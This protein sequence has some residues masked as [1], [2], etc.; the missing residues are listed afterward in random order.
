MKDIDFRRIRAHGG[1]RDRGFE[2]LVCQLASLEPREEEAVFYRKGIGADGGVECFA[3]HADGSETGWQAKYFFEFGAPQVGQLNKSIEQALDKHTKLQKFIVGLPFDLR[4][5]RIGEK[6]T[7]LERWERWKKRWEE[8]ATKNGRS[9][10]IALWSASDL[11]ERLGRDAPLYRG[12]AAF[13]FDEVVLTPEWFRSKF[14]IARAGL[15]ARYTP[16]TNIEL[17]IRRTIQYFCRC[18]ALFSEVDAWSLQVSER[19]Y[20]AVEQLR[21]HSAADTLKER[22]EKLADALQ[23]LVHQLNHTSADPGFAFPTSL[24]ET[25]IAAVHG[26]CSACN[27]ALWSLPTEEGKKRDD[28]Y[29]EYTLSQLSGLLY[30]MDEA[31]QSD[32]WRIV[33]SR[34]L[35]VSGDAGVG[36]SHLFGDAAE[37][38]I[39]QGW[40]ALL[41]LGGSFVDGD[42]W[43]QILAALGLQN[44]TSD[45]FLGALDAAGQASGTR[46]VI[47]IDAINERHGIDLWP[48]RLAAF[49]KAIEPYPH[50]GVALSCRTAYLPYI[51]PSDA[52]LA[53]LSRIEHAGFAGNPEAANAYLDRRGIVR[54]AAPNLIPEFYNPLFL[55]TCCDLLDK[56]GSKELP[57]GL[58]GVTSI[59]EFY[60]DAVAQIIETRL[61]LDRRRQIVSKALQKLASAFEDGYRGYADLDTV[62]FLLDELLPSDGTVE[63]SLLA[64]L[65]SE[66]V[67][68]VEPVTDDD[69]RLSEIVRFTFERYSDHRIATLLLNDH[70]VETDPA[71]SFEPGSKLAEFILGRDAYERAGVIEALAIQI[72][73]RCGQELPDLVPSDKN[74]HRWFVH[75]AFRASVLWRRQECFTR[76]TLDL[77]KETSELTGEDEVT[78]VLIAVAT[79]PANKFNALFLHERLAAMEMPERDAFWSMRI[80]DEGE[81]DSSPI[82]TLTSW[83]LQNGFVAIEQERARL[84]ATMLSWLFTTSHRAVRDRATKALSALLAP[85]LSIGTEL[86]ERFAS[87]N[88][89]YVLDRVL[90]AIYGAA[91]QGLDDKA[92]GDLAGTVNRHIFEGGEPPV[93]VLIRDHARGIIELADHRG[94]LSS[95]IDLRLVRPPYRSTWPLETVTADV[96][97]SYKQDYGCGRYS[98]SI[99]SSTVH[100]GDFARYVIDS[101]VDGWT[102]L[103]IEWAGSTRREI[104]EK[105]RT[106]FLKAHPRSSKRIEDVIGAANKLKAAEKREGPLHIIRIQLVSSRADARKA[107]KRDERPA[108][109]KELSKG[110]DAAERRLKRLMSRSEREDYLLLGQPHIHADLS[111]RSGHRWPPR[112]DR[113]AMRRWVCKRAHDLGWT[114]ERFGDQE[115]NLRSSG[116]MEHRVERIGKKYQWIAL[117][118]LYAHL[119]DHLSYKDT[120]DDNLGVYDGPWG[121]RGRDIDPSLLMER[122]GDDGWRSWDPTWWMPAKVQLRHVPPKTRLAWLDSDDDFVNGDHLIQVKDPKT[123]RQWLVL[124]EF[125]AWRQYGVS[126]GDKYIER[127][128][129]FALDCF[130]TKAGDTEALIAELSGR[131]LNG[132]EIPESEFPWRAYLGE[133]PWHPAI[134]DK[135]PWV[136]P[137]QWN[138]LPA[139]VQVS[140]TGYRAER[141]GYDLS[142]AETLGFKVP[143]S[144]LCSGMGLQLSSG[145]QLTYTDSNGKVLFFD[146]ST[147]EPG[148]SAALVD[149]DTFIAFLEREGLAAIW[150]LRGEKDVHGGPSHRGGYGGARHVS[151][152]YWLSQG[153]FEKRDFFERNDPSKE[154]L[155]K[156]LAGA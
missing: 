60:S 118:Q 94:V 120:F 53:D 40:P 42:P 20:R 155:E 134:A 146:P 92:L 39:E 140:V 77:L 8:V 67:I 47:F 110:L 89:L 156:L 152:V 124:S 78:R 136:Q 90:A 128:T 28:R 125:A 111:S 74:H 141:G 142:I 114:P 139:P 18:P 50:I 95:H 104:F 58:T 83:C 72:P 24:L 80:L 113:M 1:S 12:R 84:A 107:R 73:E 75:E 62:T 144:G 103:G 93:H 44:R 49:L 3:R 15:G 130:L 138:K 2:E 116:R 51:A 100:D 102:T 71:K 129:W 91:L 98:D 69:G 65:E 31:L 32:R 13:W 149:R 21:R 143:G 81:T 55:K 154:Q 106:M 5:A 131:S 59:F 9:L 151:S 87:V 126:E 34:R 86:V 48:A 43:S 14:E 7:E 61:K 46:A 25:S 99:T 54:M 26:A 52:H 108:H 122:S 23:A 37:Y 79:E 36:K 109:I 19:G 16:A 22:A 70:L 38:Q 41:L 119:A 96:I 29:G 66:G 57:R 76:R 82:E 123:R 30:D 127:G 4:D 88:D 148:P 153:R 121:T 147:R 132:R 68:A 64:Q 112:P 105:W 33:N 150:T 45:E 115:R 6:Q 97:E 145:R 101:V 117:H 27:R 133:F 10:E 85:R 56:R 35:L 135:D 11:T 63:R 17:P 137:D